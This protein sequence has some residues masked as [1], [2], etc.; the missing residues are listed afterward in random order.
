VLV[1]Y[2]PR[3]PVLYREEEARI[4]DAIGHRLIA[5]EHVGSTSVPGLAAKPII[6]IMAAI[7]SLDTAQEFIVPLHGL[8][9]EYV[10]EYEDVLPERRY[11]RKGPEGARTHHLHMVELESHFWTRHILFRDFL[12]AHP[13]EASLYAQLKRGLAAQYGADRLGYQDAKGPYIT[14]V[15]EKARVA[16]EINLLRRSP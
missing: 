16:S 3:W 15:E 7:D 5:I 12:R 6:D 1:E 2:D 11:F 8:G 10:P 9:Y 14:S 13:E 4:L